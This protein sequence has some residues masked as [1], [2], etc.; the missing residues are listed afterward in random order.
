VINW[1]QE[2]Q[3]LGQALDPNLTEQPELAV[4]YTKKW[5][6]PTPQ[7]APQFNGVF[8]FW[9][10]APQIEWVP[11]LGEASSLRDAQALDVWNKAKATFTYGPYVRTPPYVFQSGLVPSPAPS[12]APAP[13][14]TPS[15]APSPAPPQ[16]RQ[17][18]PSGS[19][20]PLLVVGAIAI[21]I[22]ALAW[23]SRQRLLALARPDG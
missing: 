8:W 10:L 20:V 16:S 7:S 6:V 11:K 13:A 3:S 17:P 14:P 23:G 4:E 19:I 12:P 22:G 5:G 15:P 2:F 9:E 1:I 21:G 18:K